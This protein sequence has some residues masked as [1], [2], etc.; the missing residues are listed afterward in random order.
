MMF[1]FVIPLS[2]GIAAGPPSPRVAWLFFFVCQQKADQHLFGGSEGS[3][4]N[5]RTTARPRCVD[6][7]GFHEL[8]LEYAT[9]R[10]AQLVFN[11]FLSVASSV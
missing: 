9:P 2:S 5:G 11:A 10:T 1:G 3:E 8:T 7:L 4:E 6:A